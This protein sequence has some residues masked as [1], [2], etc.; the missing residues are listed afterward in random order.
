M[1]FT[2]KNTGSHSCSSREANVSDYYNKNY[3]Y[4]KRN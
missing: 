1:A 3:S 2:I 4:C